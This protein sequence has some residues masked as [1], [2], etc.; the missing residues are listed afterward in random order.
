MSEVLL[1]QTE[2]PQR[3]RQH[4]RLLLGQLL[5][6][7]ARH[8]LPELVRRLPRGP[9]LALDREAAQLRHRLQHLRH[10]LQRL[11]RR[12]GLGLPAVALALPRVGRGARRRVGRRFVG[13]LRVAGEE[14]SQHHNH[15]E[16]LHGP[17][18]TALRS[19][20]CSPRR[21]Q[22]HSSSRSLLS[23]CPMLTS[24]RERSAAIKLSSSRPLDLEVALDR[25]A[26]PL[27]ELGPRR[28]QPP[29]RRRTMHAVDPRDP[30]R[31]QPVQEL[32]PQQV[33]LS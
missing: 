28:L 20:D 21:G 1:H 30:L 4:L 23:S 11:V 6:E 14:K 8:E 12:V 31:A 2:V 22:S 7:L 15:A 26:R 16:T 13:L 17:P 5:L 3:R 10:A 29:K 25:A 33:A 24:M 9:D 32:V 19:A 18:C 27:E